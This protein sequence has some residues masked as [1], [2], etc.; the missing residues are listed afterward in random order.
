MIASRLLSL[1]MVLCVGGPLAAQELV[2]SPNPLAALA[3]AT[4]KAFVEQPLFEP[5]RRPPAVAQP[6]VYVAPPAP[7]VVEQPPSLRLIGLVE[8][9]H[10]FVAVVHH[11]GKTETLHSGDR[12]G[13][14]KVQVMTAN[15]RVISGDLAFDYRLFAGERSQGPE[16]VQMPSA[17]V[18]PAMA[19]RDPAQA[20]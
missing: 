2:R 18:M 1:A 9:A 5:S 20:R 15:L 3:P 16:A 17:P 19:A 8:S 13:S 7:V 14:W 12:I 11:N 6:Y 4:L 10:S